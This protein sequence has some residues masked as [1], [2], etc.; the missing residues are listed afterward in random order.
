MNRNNM[1]LEYSEAVQSETPL[2]ENG[3]RRFNRS[4]GFSLTIILTGAAAV[5][6]AASVFSVLN[7]VLLRPLPYKDP[8]RLA[9][10]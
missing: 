6:M 1:F 4:P 3:Q 8:A 5:G 9:S 2:P 7:A 10:I